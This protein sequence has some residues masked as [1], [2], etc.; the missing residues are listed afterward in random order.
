MFPNKLLNKISKDLIIKPLFKHYTAGETIKDLHNKI[1][2]LQKSNI[3]PIGDYIKEFSN[4][5]GVIFENFK[6]YQNLC[7]IA[8]LE[9]IAIKPSSFS[10][11]YNDIKNITSVI[12]KS[13][14]KVLIDAEDAKNHSIINNIVKKLAIDFKDND[15]YHIY[16]TYQ[17]YRRD[18]LL[19]L[20]EDSTYNTV[21]IKLVRG[22][23]LNTD[24]HLPEFFN[25]KIDTDNAF[26][27]GMNFI[28]S[29]NIPSFICTHNLE[30]IK[31]MIDS[32]NKNKDLLKNIKHASLYGFINNETQKIITSG[33]KTY[34][35][36]PYGNIDD[37]IPYLVRRLQENPSILKHLLN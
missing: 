22:A 14:K 9:Y 8:E 5:K 20:K 2:V 27:D 32:V 3:Y 12:I 13:K 37:A 23:Y 4:D 21:G 31:H 1:T 35:Y 19:S 33:I 25:K 15:K 24:G 34:K 36:L 17:M 7:L 28:F 26:R 11:N 29:K 18:S 6:N 10:F 16:K 30:D